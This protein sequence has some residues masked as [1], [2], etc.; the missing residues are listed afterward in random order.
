MN[1]TVIGVDLGTSGVKAGCFDREGNVTSIAHAEYPKEMPRPGWAE[2]NPD[3]WWSALVSALKRLTDAGADP[4]NVAAVAVG[5]QAPCMAPLDNSYRPVAPALIWSD[6]RASEEAAEISNKSGRP[7]APNALIAKSLWLARHRPEAFERCTRIL[8][9][10]E[11]AIARLCGAAVALHPL[12]AELVSTSGLDD[13]LFGAHVLPGTIVGSLTKDAAADTGLPVG[14]PIVSGWVDSFMGIIG[15]G[16]V[17]PGQACLTGGSAGTVTIVCEDLPGLNKAPFTVGGYK[18]VSKVLSGT[19]LALEW[20]HDKLASRATYEDLFAEAAQTSVGQ[21]PTFF[22]FLSTCAAPRDETATH[23]A[24]LGL[25]FSHTRG[26]L[27]RALLEGVAFAYRDAIEEL[28]SQGVR[29]TDVRH[30]GGQTRSEFWN[31]VKADVLGRPVTVPQIN[32]SGTLGAAILA[33]VAIGWYPGIPE[34]VAQLTRL[35][36][37]YSPDAQRQSV[38]EKAL[39][40]RREMVSALGAISGGP[41][42]SR[43]VGSS[44]EP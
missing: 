35:G 33:A 7:V 38:Y 14:T 34:A 40:R 21:G 42:G 29:A 25:D 39:I 15:A 18:S 32:E 5:G 3:D 37:T 6:E 11:F 43:P 30:N 19:G 31:Q 10:G 8:G 1:E 12:S 9:C 44:V 28:E 22:P 2:Q 16:V 26:Q 41:P 27:M 20:F 36:A 17:S 23:S 13:R 24:W 4:S